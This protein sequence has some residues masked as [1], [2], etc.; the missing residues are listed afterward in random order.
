MT[1]VTAAS[2]A[3]ST[4]ADLR[5]VIIGAGMSGILSAIKLREAGLENFAI[6]EK[7]ERLGGTWRENTYAGGA[8]DVPS[9][10][11]S[12]SE[13]SQFGRNGTQPTP[14]S[15]DTKF[16]AG[17][18]SRWSC[19]CCGDPSVLEHEHPEVGI[20]IHDP[21]RLQHRPGRHAQVPD[22]TEPAEHLE[23]AVGDVDLPPV[24]AHLR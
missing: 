13:Q 21:I 17:N 12:D 5:V 1:R 8:C 15:T 11:Y 19:S 4:V 24:K 22:Q 23:Q 3:D 14:L 20:A 9:H 18:R 7:A 6:Y 2:P 16:K 10:L